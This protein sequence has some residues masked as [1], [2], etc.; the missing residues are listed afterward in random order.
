MEVFC[1]IYYICSYTAGIPAIVK[2]LKIKKSN[3]YSL[4]EAI[5]TIVG[6]TCWTIYIFSTEQSMLVYIGT[7]IDEIMIVIWN[8][9]VI[10]YFNINLRKDDK[11][12]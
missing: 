9:L 7:I 1:I 12:G 11:N 3:D 2:L 5:L 6:T 10:K 8:G 4:I